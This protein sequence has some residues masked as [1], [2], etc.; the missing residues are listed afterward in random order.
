[1]QKWEYKIVLIM[2]N[3]F[4]DSTVSCGSSYA[5]SNPAAAA[6]AELGGDGWELVTVLE[7][8]GMYRC[9]FKRPKA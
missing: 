5:S 7:N 8:A 9:F 1:M 3:R 6:L 2:E 4:Q